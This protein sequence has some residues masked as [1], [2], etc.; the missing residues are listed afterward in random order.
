MGTDPQIQKLRENM[1]HK[2]HEI[3]TL[4]GSL[5]DSISLI[6][7]LKAKLDEKNVRES[8]KEDEL[9]LD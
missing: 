9:H 1:E 4:R 2:N 8:L 5:Q 6:E 7:S 3:E